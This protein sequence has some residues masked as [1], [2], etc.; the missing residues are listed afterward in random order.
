MNTYPKNY[1]K[2]R[3]R[4]FDILSM[5]PGV[6]GN[7]SFVHVLL[8]NI[9]FDSLGHKAGCIQDLFSAP[10]ARKKIPFSNV[11]LTGPPMTF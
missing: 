5:L 10:H 2:Y 11:E 3:I 1:M 9:Q 7:C 8:D 4:L 6:E